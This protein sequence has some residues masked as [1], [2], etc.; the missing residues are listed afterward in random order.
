MWGGGLEAKLPTSSIVNIFY[1]R[2]SLSIIGE[3]DVI[4]KVISP[5]CSFP[6]YLAAL[7]AGRLAEHPT[8]AVY[9]LHYTTLTFVPSPP[10]LRLQ[11]NTKRSFI[12][13]WCHF[14]N[15]SYIYLEI[16]LELWRTLLIAK[17]ITAAGNLYP[18]LW[19]RGRRTAM[20]TGV[21][22]KKHLKYNKDVCPTKRSLKRKMDWWLVLCGFCTVSSILSIFF[23]SHN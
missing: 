17:L 10:S 11:E 12:I 1:D 9:T 20:R 19:N 23:S 21:F 4:W 22:L 6:P 7:L 14:T 16:L 2:T 8:P 3:N 13:W 5:W 18:I 15:L